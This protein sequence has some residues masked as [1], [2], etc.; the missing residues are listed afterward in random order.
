MRDGRRKKRDEGKVYGCVGCR[1]GR[2]TIPGQF[3]PKNL[4]K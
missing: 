2:T 4:G 1:G 3:A